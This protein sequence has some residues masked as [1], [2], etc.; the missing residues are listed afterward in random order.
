MGNDSVHSVD[1]PSAVNSEQ[2]EE[3]RTGKRNKGASSVSRTDKNAS[4]AIDTGGI[5]NRQMKTKKM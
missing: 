5:R 3:K 1:V 2:M 4:N